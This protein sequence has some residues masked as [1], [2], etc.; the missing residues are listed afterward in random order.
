MKYAL[1]AFYLCI[2]CWTWIGLRAAN[3]LEPAATLFIKDYRQCDRAEKLAFK[4]HLRVLHKD[5]PN[6]TCRLTVSGSAAD[7]QQMHKDVD[8]ALKHSGVQWAE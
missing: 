6:G 1:I 4:H 7:M 8:K 3:G 5:K 2:A